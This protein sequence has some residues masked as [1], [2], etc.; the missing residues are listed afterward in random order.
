MKYLVPV[1]VLLQ[2]EHNII[3][4]DL[5]L[6]VNGTLSLHDWQLISPSSWVMCFLFITDCLHL[7][8]FFD[9]VAVN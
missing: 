4:L 1:T 7:L 6:G 9:I 2:T 8:Q 3:W 5:G